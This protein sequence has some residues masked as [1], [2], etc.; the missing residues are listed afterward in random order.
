MEIVFLVT[1]ILTTL[2]S[3]YILGRTMY[4]HKGLLRAYKTSE[5]LFMIHL[6]FGVLLTMVL[7]ITLCAFN[8]TFWHLPYLTR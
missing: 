7:F 2:I 8:N 4:T 1:S 6:V 3:I 5:F